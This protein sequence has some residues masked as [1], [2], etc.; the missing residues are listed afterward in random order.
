MD[1]NTQGTAGWNKKSLL[2][3]TTWMSCAYKKLKKGDQFCT[4]EH[5]HKSQLAKYHHLL[6]IPTV[7]RQ[8]SDTMVQKCVEWIILLLIEDQNKSSANLFSGLRSGGWCNESYLLYHRKNIQVNL[9][10]GLFSCRV[11]LQFFSFFLN[12]PESTHSSPQKMKTNVDWRATIWQEHPDKS[13]LLYVTH[14][15][16]NA[17]NQHKGNV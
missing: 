16:M 7:G 5:K 14:H 15:T 4:F 3:T 2:R 10:T 9:R 17:I 13:F 8:T 6:S 11:P 1:T 12:M